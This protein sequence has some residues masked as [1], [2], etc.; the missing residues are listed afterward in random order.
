MPLIFAERA[1]KEKMK[2]K[3]IKGVSTSLVAIRAKKCK[4]LD[5][6]RVRISGCHN[7]FVAMW[8]LFLGD[9]KVL[10][11]VSCGGGGGDYDGDNGSK[12]LRLISITTAFTL[13]RF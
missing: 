11:H 6:C 5:L 12:G 10:G 3:Y 1:G 2:F 13:L 4:N 7:S 9:N 8:L